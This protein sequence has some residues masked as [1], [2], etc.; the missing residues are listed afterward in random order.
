MMEE[1]GNNANDAADNVAQY[2]PLDPRNPEEKYVWVLERHLNQHKSNNKYQCKSCNKVFCGGRQRIR[3]HITGVQEGSQ[4]VS[5]CPR[6]NPE[7]IAEFA[8][9][10]CQVRSRAKKRKNLEGTAAPA[11]PVT[12]ETAAPAP[13]TSSSQT[14]DE[15]HRAQIRMHQMQILKTRHEVLQRAVES[16][17]FHQLSVHEQEE[18]RMAW[19]KLTIM[20]GDVNAELDEVA[21][22]EVALSSMV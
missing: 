10:S 7:A 15:L 17:A 6:P 11:P 13:S 3:I 19:L 16:S 21:G 22:G 12:V 4:Q 18:L 14:L 2:L 8:D 20:V 1:G 9:R 5:V